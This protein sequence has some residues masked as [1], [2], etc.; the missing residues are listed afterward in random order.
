M[1]SQKTESILYHDSPSGFYSIDK[2]EIVK[3]FQAWKCL[4]TW[5]L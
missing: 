2:G 3:G 1:E 4:Q 5:V